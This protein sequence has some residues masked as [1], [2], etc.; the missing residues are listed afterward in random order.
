MGSNDRSKFEA[1]LALGNS[2][3]ARRQRAAEG[4]KGGTVLR[5]RLLPPIAAPAALNLFGTPTSTVPSMTP[6]EPVAAVPTDAALIAAWRGGDEPAAAELV[7]RHAR[8]LAR[9]L[10]GA[11]AL[12]ADVDDLVQ[13]TFIRAFRALGRFRGPCQFRTWLM[14]IG[15]NVLKDAHRRSRR[16]RVVPL[17]DDLRATD[18]DPHE[19]AVAGEAERRLVAGLEQLPRMQREVFLLRAQQGLEYEEIAAA[20]GTTPG[21][22][23]VHYHHAVKR[24]KEHLA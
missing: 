5:Y 17:G 15:G 23:R 18:G 21:A 10:A 16:A 7:R 9:F 6:A 11:G 1:G 13:E 8:A 12:A 22:A 19:R 4:G 14:T 2:R 20:L 24:L 3:A